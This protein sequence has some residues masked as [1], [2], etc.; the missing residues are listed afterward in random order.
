[1][2]LSDFKETKRV[3]GILKTKKG[4]HSSFCELCFCQNPDT[5][6]G[7]TT[8]CNERVIGGRECLVNTKQDDVMNYLGTKFEC[9]SNGSGSRKEF[10]LENKKKSFIIDCSK[11]K[12]SIIE[13]VKFYT[14]GLRKEK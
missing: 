8:C 10:E 3:E 13:D 1:M 5:E 11:D 6:D 9:S 4:Q 7:Y 2:K 12:K 14:K